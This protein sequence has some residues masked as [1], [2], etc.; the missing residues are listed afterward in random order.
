MKTPAAIL[1]GRW[2]VSDF[3]TRPR[4]KI[5]PSSAD[6]DIRIIEPEWLRRDFCQSLDKLR[7]ANADELPKDSFDSVETDE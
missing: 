2:L 1:P 7:A 6:A 4:P 3:K 5:V